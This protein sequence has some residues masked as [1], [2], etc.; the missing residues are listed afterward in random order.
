MCWNN[1]FFIH[2]RPANVIL[3]L[4]DFDNHAWLFVQVYFISFLLFFSQQIW[5]SLGPYSVVFKLFYVIVGN[6]CIIFFVFFK[7]CKVKRLSRN[8]G[9]ASFEEPGLLG[10]RGLS[11]L[12]TA[13]PRIK[14]LWICTV[15][16][17]PGVCLVAYQPWRCWTEAMEIE[18]SKLLILWINKINLEAIQEEPGDLQC[19]VVLLWFLTNDKSLTQ[20]LWTLNFC[21]IRFLFDTVL[22]TH[23]TSNFVCHY[24]QKKSPSWPATY[25]SN[26]SV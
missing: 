20:S 19:G 21:T 7:F 10:L 26:L 11:P 16:P 17:Y 13:K 5:F 4:W 1:H 12:S 2:S 25:R 18:T 22:L 15:E 24:K 9:A 23:S 6:D 14:W 8:L 3:L